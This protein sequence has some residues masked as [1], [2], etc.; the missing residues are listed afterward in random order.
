[1]GRITARY[2]VT[3]V[4]ESGNAETHMWKRGDDLAGEEP[5]EIHINGTTYATT[6]RTP[7]NDVELIH[8]LLAAEGIITSL[9]D[10]VGIRHRSEYNGAEVAL[11][12]SV[13]YIP[14]IRA[15][16]MNSACGVCGRDS[17]DQLRE[18]WRYPMSDNK[19]EWPADIVLSMPGALFNHQPGFTKTG[20]FHAAAL[21]DTQGNVLVA[22]EDVGRHNAVDKVLG[23]AMMNNLRPGSNLALAVSGRASF[24]LVQK[25][26]SAGV[27]LL[28]AVSAPSSMAVDLAREGDLT[29]CGFVRPPEMT[30]YSREDRV[31]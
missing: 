8:G 1:M 22:R 2:R 31:V 21:I 29:L 12:N 15:T 11:S 25:A 16:V 4:V 18:T 23:W 3:K 30:I 10:I 24:E 7:G 14:P 19:T 9:R 5:L 6:M 13:T 27:P 28:A 17:I 20:G 26:I